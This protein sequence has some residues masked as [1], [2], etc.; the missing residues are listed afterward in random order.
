MRTLFICIFVFC[1][2][3]AWGQVNSD[4]RTLLDELQVPET[5]QQAASKLV[6]LGQSQPAVRAWLSDELPAMLLHVKDLDVV[7]SEAKLAGKLKLESCTPSLIV[8]LSQRNEAGGPINL[9]ILY[10][11]RDDPVGKALLDI[12][13]PAVSALAQPLESKDGH[14]RWR[15]IRVLQ[16]INSPKSRELLQKHLP[17]EDASDLRNIIINGLAPSN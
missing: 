16:R 2:A 10:E 6:S 1:S 4:S 9:T 8:L 15:A 12:G 14:T 5:T 13:E 11:M 17:R 7:R 3:S